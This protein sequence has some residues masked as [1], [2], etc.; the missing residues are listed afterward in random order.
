MHSASSWTVD[1]FG[2]EIVDGR[3]YGLGICDQKASI[4]AGRQGIDLAQALID[5]ADEPVGVALVGA[6]REF[7]GELWAPGAD[8]C[9]VSFGKATGRK[10]PTLVPQASACA[11]PHARACG[12]GKDSS[13]LPPFVLEGMLW[14]IKAWHPAPSRP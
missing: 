11:P 4:A 7:A 9:R 2:G 5:P 6:V 13:C 10:P 1:P 8:A 3:L 14:V 12:Y